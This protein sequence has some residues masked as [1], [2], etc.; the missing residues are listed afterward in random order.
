MKR[1]AENGIK[2]WELTDNLWERVRKFIPRRKLIPPRQALQAVFYV[3]RTGI[4]W[5]A[6]LREYG[7]ASSIHGYFSERAQAGFFRRMWQE[8]LVRYEKKAENYRALVE[9]ACAFIRKSGL[10]PRRTFGSSFLRLK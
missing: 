5:K 10:I 8:G 6:L 4:Q 9:F 3:P 2:S 1:I 7:A